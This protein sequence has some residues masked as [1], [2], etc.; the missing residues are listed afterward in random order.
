MK[1]GAPIAATSGEHVAIRAP[2][3]MDPST[4]FKRLGPVSRLRDF[5]T[6]TEDVH[7]LAH[8][9]VAHVDPAQWRLRIDGMVER[10]LVF[11]LE[12]LLRF[13]P[14]DLTAVFECYGNPLEPDVPTRSVA[15]VVWRGVTLGVLLARSGVRS[16]ATVV[17]LEGLDSGTFADVYCERYI[18][19]I[20]VARALQEDVLV[21]Y[22]MNGAPLTHE[23][24]FPA[25][26]IVP[27]YFGTSSVKWLSRITLA[28]TRPEGLFT[29]QLYNR[30]VGLGERDREPARELDVN[31]VI[32]L[33][34]DR[35]RLRA[36]RHLVAGW[37]WSSSA[38]ARVDVSTDGGASW[39]EAHLV[40]QESTPTW[41]H[42]GFEWEAAVP[43]SYEIRAR[44][45]DSQGRVQ[46]SAGRN[47][48]HTI[49]VTVE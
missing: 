24:G 40:E 39:H 28:A 49:T 10:P 27:G 1:K 33:P 34:A 37:A 11:D 48:V 30:R 31:L 9:G 26:V 42:F 29:T 32:V 19:D 36:G 6:P 20:P 2:V 18:K 7:V 45:T 8:L 44:A 46:P 25:R 13:P 15:N 16:D 23:H 14:R 17:C 43:G 3:I 21:A 38:I 35:D 47:A 41:Q 5:V 12:E 22:A 4:P